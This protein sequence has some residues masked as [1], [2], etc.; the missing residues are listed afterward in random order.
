M[1]RSKKDPHHLK[2]LKRLF[3]VL[4]AMWIVSF[5]NESRAAE[6]CDTSKANLS[7]CPLIVDQTHHTLSFNRK[8]ESVEKVTSIR[9]Y[10]IIGN[11]LDVLK[12][13][14]ESEF[15]FDLSTIPDGIYFF[16]LRE[17]DL[18]SSTVVRCVKSANGIAANFPNRN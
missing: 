17:P 15:V 7:S 14:N 11:D 4:L 9:F 6:A 12:A 3:F 8:I 16:I 10:N 18:L 2:I 5:P 1:L 13:K